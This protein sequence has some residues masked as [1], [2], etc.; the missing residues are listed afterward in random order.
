MCFCYKFFTVHFGARVFVLSV[1]R[2]YSYVHDWKKKK[3][4][5]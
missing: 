1:R 5:L 2:L 4:I 3:Y